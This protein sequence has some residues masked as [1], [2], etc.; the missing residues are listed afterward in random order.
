MKK[1]I[2]PFFAFLIGKHSARNATII[3]TALSLISRVFG[4]GRTLLIAYLFGAT[5]FVDAYYVALGAVSFVPFTLNTTIEAAVLPA[6][7][8]N[9]KQTARDLF[10]FVFLAFSIITFL[11]MLLLLTFPTEY[12]KLFARTFD[13]TRIAY[14]AAMVK[15]LLPYAMGILLVGLFSTWANYENR[16][17]AV[18]TVMAFANIFIITA[19]LL[20]Y[21]IM[22]E[23]ALAAFQSVGYIFLVIIIWYVLRGLPLYP[24]K[25]LPFSL[26]HR[27][28]RDFLLRVFASGAA[29]LFT[30][31]D[32]Y[33]ASSLPE[34]NVSAISYA[35]LIFTQPTGLTAVAFAIY[36]VRANEAVASNKDNSEL[37]STTL[38]MVFSYFIPAAI[39][40]AIVANPIITLLLGHGA[41]DAKAIEM[42]YP[43]LAIL[44]LG[45]PVFICNMILSKHA[46]ALGKLKILITWEYFGV[47]GNIILNWAL[48]SK[49]GAAGL[50]LATVIM[51]HISTTGLMLFFCRSY[52]HL[53][54]K[55]VAPQMLI[56]LLWR[57]PLYFL[58]RS[59]IYLPLIFVI[60]VGIAHYLL[61]EKYGFFAKIPTRWRPSIIAEA[62]FQRFRKD[63]IV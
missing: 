41:F 9:D 26:M 18:S 37:L 58:T 30:I 32:R 2:N 62:L 34:G 36:F 47:L 42:T 25:K 23:T 15:W 8:Q 60:C 11:I 29:L 40:L 35:Y 7:I 10:G 19:L 33:F 31:I 20:L 17:A 53:L 54:L 1:T 3:T 12:I 27:V 46:M 38:L 61:C 13:D 5:G 24:Q 39:L 59:G 44:A 63:K 21:P 43:C 16:F 57:I 45:L 50:C 48:V 49:Y 56:T 14:A 55:L 22:G 28:S 52:L 6:M 4:Y 51:W